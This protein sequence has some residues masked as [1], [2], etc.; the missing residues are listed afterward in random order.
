MVK[1]LVRISRPKQ[2][3][4]NLFVFAGVFFSGKWDEKEYFVCG[5]LL[6]VA[7]T[8]AAI[9]VYA[10]NDSF[11]V[12]KDKRHPQKKLRPLPAGELKVIHALVFALVC[13]MLAVSIAV[14]VSHSA[15]YFLT[16]YVCMNVLYSFKLKHVAIVD[17]FIISFGFLFRLFAGTLGLG[18]VASSWLV[19]CTLMLT[20]FLGFNKRLAEFKSIN[21]EGKNS[22]REVLNE[23]ELGFLEYAVT[24]TSVMTLMSYALYTLSPETIERHGTEYLIVTFLPV[25]YATLKYQYIVSISELG[26]D[27]SAIVIKNK[28]IIISVILWL[29]LFMCFL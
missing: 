28:S 8:L 4:K 14:F 23:Y 3:I 6:F 24:V 10:I 22:S 17:V 11:D 16:A 2:W 5:L 18:I 7:F 21:V 15:L 20:L 27:P 19:L 13:I 9:A 29:T 12:E 26:Q 1:S 25:F